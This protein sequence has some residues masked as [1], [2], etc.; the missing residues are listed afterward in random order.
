MNKRIFLPGLALLIVAGMVFARS[1]S[2][3]SNKLTKVGIVNLHPSGS[4]YREANGNTLDAQLNA[5]RQFLTE[6][7]DCPLISGADVNG[8]DS[9]LGSAKDAGVK[10]FLFD[11]LLNVDRGLYGAAVISDTENQGK[12]SVAWLKSLNLFAYNSIHI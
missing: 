6:G 2:S 8:W 10:V 1:S 3:G 9:V 12:A 11:G 5:A 7:V 4:G